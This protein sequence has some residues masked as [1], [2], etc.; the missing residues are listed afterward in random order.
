MIGYKV[1]GGPNGE[2]RMTTIAGIVC[3]DGIVLGSDSLATRGP[4]AR[5]EYLKIW[6]LSVGSHMP[7]VITG[8]GQGAYIAKYREML[9]GEC[10]RR[11]RTGPPLDDSSGFVTLAEQTMQDL[12]R[13]YGTERFARLGLLDIGSGGS[14]TSTRGILPSLTAVIGVFHQEPHLY[15]VLPDGI[16]EEQQGFGSEGS[17]SPY[18][19]YLLP[20]FYHP[21]ITLDDAALCVIYIIEQV[22]HVDP[23]SGGPTQVATVTRNGVRLWATEDVMQCTMS[24]NE[25]D[26]EVSALWKESITKQSRKKK[27]PRRKKKA[28]SRRGAASKRPSRKKKV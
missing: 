22:K 10:E 15:F 24:V 19:D 18:A 14:P 4:S 28:A 3:Q 13:T 25:I 6:E 27:A 23:H 17:G 16:A 2:H 12:S 20:R 26:K 11:M 9:Q 5:E 7:A 21:G 8:A 1:S